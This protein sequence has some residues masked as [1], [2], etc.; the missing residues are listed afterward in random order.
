MYNADNLFKIANI[1]WSLFYWF[2]LPKD[3]KE[4][5]VIVGLTGCFQELTSRDRV[6]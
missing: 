4:D 6:N 5:H 3:I 1:L 2:V